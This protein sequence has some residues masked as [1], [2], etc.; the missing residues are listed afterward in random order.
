M[1]GCRKNSELHRA[2]P[3]ENSLPAQ[4]IALIPQGKQY[5]PTCHP[6]NP[7]QN[8]SRRPSDFM[9]NKFCKHQRANSSVIWD[10]WYA[11]LRGGGTGIMKFWSERKVVFGMLWPQHWIKESREWWA[12]SWD[13]G[14][15]GGGLAKKPETET[16]WRNW[17]K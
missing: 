16:H 8:G 12:S 1:D 17:H 4:H 9:A 10:S 2:K 5:Q 3:R 6:T 11:S 7:T 13:Y 14:D 15:H